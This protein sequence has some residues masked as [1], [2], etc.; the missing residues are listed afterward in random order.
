M[1]LAI[2]TDTRAR[3]H[4]TEYALLYNAEKKSWSVLVIDGERVAVL[5]T[6]ETKAEAVRA[7]SQVKGG[8][9]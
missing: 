4:A 8:A 9:R 2:T 1:N 6:H 7:L 5:S 3:V